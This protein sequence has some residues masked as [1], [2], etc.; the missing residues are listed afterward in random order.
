MNETMTLVERLRNPS[1]TTPDS[2][3]T[4]DVGRTRS[5]M[6][7]AARRIEKLETVINLYLADSFS[8]NGGAQSMFEAALSDEPLPSFA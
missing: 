2:Q 7:A 8:C 1:W 6:D 5:D 3:T 4:L